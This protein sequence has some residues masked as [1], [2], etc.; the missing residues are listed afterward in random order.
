MLRKASAL[1]FLVI[2]VAVSIACAQSSSG[3]S[4]KTTG[5]KQTHGTNPTSTPEPR[6][7]EG[8]PTT[9]GAEQLKVEITNTYM[10]QE[11]IPEFHIVGL[12]TNNGSEIIAGIQLTFQVMDATGH[13][14]I[15]N[16]QNGYDPN[17]TSYLPVDTLFPGDASPFDFGFWLDEAPSSYKVDVTSFMIFSDGQRANVRVQNVRRVDGGDGFLYLSGELVNLESQ[18]VRVWNLAGAVS[19][20]SDTIRAASDVSPFHRGDLAPAGD[21]QGREVTP[22]VIQV[23]NPGIAAEKDLF[24]YY[25]ELSS[26]PE[27]W[28]EAQMTNPYA[29][30]LGGYHVVG[31]VTNPG[32]SECIPKVFAALYGRDGSVLDVGYD[33]FS[34]MSLMPGDKLP[35]DTATFYYRGKPLDTSLVDHIVVQVDGCGGGEAFESALAFV[36]LETSD[37]QVQKDGANWTLTGSVRNTSERKLRDIGVRAAVLDSKGNPMACGSDSIFPTGDRFAPGDTGTYEIKVRLDPEADTN[38]YTT[39]TYVQGWYGESD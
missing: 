37:E 18:W 29:D 22:F 20:E 38:G 27:I 32:S 36:S 1:S 3:A 6:M 16:Y 13:S 23:P 2:L 7:A 11:Y 17:H 28:P 9:E 26:P 21:S 19:D 4:G 39:K 8:K 34:F 12:V 25:T 33:F 15:K 24:F 10:G 5:A 35:F 30:S 31:W 14:L